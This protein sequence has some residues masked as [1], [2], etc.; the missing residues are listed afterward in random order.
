M[1]TG[2]S[3]TIGVRL[4][5]S[6]GRWV[7]LATVLGSCLAGV[8]ATVVSIALPSIGQDLHASFGEL[9]WTVTGY[10][11]TLASLILLGGAAGD[12]FG[13]RR[14]FVVGS[15]WFTAAS[16]LCALAPGIHALIVARALQGIGGALVTPASLAIIQS[17]FAASDRAKAV[18]AW[19]AFSGVAG[20]LAPFVGGGLLGVASWRWVFVINVPLAAIVVAIAQRHVPPSRDL[21]A[22]GGMDW[23]GG[24]LSIV[25]LGGVT[26]AIIAAPARGFSIQVWLPALVGVAGLIGFVAVE[27]QVRRPALPHELFRSRQ[28]TVVNAVTFLVYGALGAYFF[29][30]VVELQV[31]CGYSPLTAGLSLIPITAI[32]LLLST[33]SGAL[34]QRIGPRIQMATGPLICTC[35]LLLSLRLSPGARYLTDVLPAVTVFGLGLACMVAPLTAAALSSVPATHVGAGS[36]VNNAVA[37][38]ASLLAIAAIPALTGLTRNAGTAGAFLHGFRSSLWLCI[39]LLTAGS[40]LAAA[41][42]RRNAL[43]A[44]P[45]HHSVPAAMKTHPL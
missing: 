44:V 34:A 12:R 17:S 4:S 25:G 29:L 35:G 21:D 6:S 38:A 24:A 7:L 45:A 9:Q 26:Y 37:R 3:G 16:V 2:P 32:T 14:I 36:G 13:R 22:T 15:V 43:T 8:D 5:S 27:R 20:A 33:R 19:A 42:V 39:A 28:F 11:V 10:T 18:G 40:M 31:V 30:L 41:G 23:G 1:T